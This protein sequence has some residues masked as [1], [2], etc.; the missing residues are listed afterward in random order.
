MRNKIKILSSCNP[1]ISLNIFPNFGDSYAAS[2]LNN[3][4]LGI[5]KITSFSGISFKVTIPLPVEGKIA[6]PKSFIFPFFSL[7]KFSSLRTFGS[8]V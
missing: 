5:S 2:T 1:S 8:K 6:I 7:T 4:F 3:K